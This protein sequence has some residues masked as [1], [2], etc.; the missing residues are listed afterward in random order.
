MEVSNP[1]CGV[2][3]GSNKTL[4]FDINSIQNKLA[5]SEIQTPST[6]AFQHQQLLRQKNY[7]S[8]VV[9]EAMMQP[10]KPPSA[11]PRPQ[12]TAQPAPLSRKPPV[13]QPPSQDRVE[14]HT[15]SISSRASVYD[16]RKGSG[17]AERSVRRAARPLTPIKET[18]EAKVVP[19][20]RSVF[21]DPDN[22]ILFLNNGLKIMNPVNAKTPP[23]PL[24]GEV[25]EEE[26]YDPSE[27]FYDHEKAE[28]ERKR[29]LQMEQ[30]KGKRL[31][32][33]VVYVY[34]SDSDDDK[35]H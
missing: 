33:K 24:W 34:E 18:E 20:S 19:P 8:D 5:H 16:F 21:A 14:S 3:R 17:G 11:L 12:P 13:Y 10:F 7:Q 29:R 22:G 4:V 25:L 28:R 9:R 26:N 31:K 35:K 30:K 15:F 6:K 1:F 27:E 32:K 23:P 2:I